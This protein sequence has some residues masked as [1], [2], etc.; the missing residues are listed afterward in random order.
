MKDQYLSHLSTTELSERSKYLI[1]NLT[2]RETTGK[3]GLRN[4]AQETGQSL[5]R[6]FTHVLQELDNRNEKQNPGFLKDSNVPTAMIDKSNKLIDL[7]QLAKNKNPHLIKFGIK[8]FLKNY[9]VKVSLASSFNDPSLNTAQMDNEMK[10][11]FTPHPNEVELRRLDGRKIEGVLGINLELQITRDY[12][13]YCSS[14]K[15]DNRLFSDFKADACLFI[16]DSQQFSEDL[17]KYMCTQ[18]NIEDHAYKPVTY[19]D[20]IRPDMGEKPQVEFHKH[21][22]FLY[23]N[24]Y[25]HVFI[26]KKDN[27]LPRNIIF[28]MQEAKEY[29]ELICL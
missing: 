20:P 24:E 1:E 8:K 26:P 21:I 14:L 10:A 29:S 22:K 17:F 9:S 27:E 11:I 23:Q 3:I 5:M 18:I 16:Y 7:A 2:T 15:F 4:I 25:R 28:K 12:Y 19:L 13:I 6:K